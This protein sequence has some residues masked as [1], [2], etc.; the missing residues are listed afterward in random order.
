MK[1]QLVEILKTEE[2][3]YELTDILDK[4]EIKS[5]EDIQVAI[6]SL[7]ELENDYVHK[8]ANAIYDNATEIATAEG[9]KMLTG[10]TIINALKMWSGFIPRTGIMLGEERVSGD[11]YL[12]TTPQ[13]QGVY[14][15]EFVVGD[16]RGV[17]KV[18]VK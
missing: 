16:E 8:Y 18:V 11:T 6:K 12:S 3:A 9:L 13:Q 14:L 5:S 7:N 17:K 2:T 10:R 1:E 4:L 15:L